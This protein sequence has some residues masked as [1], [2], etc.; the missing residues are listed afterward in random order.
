MDFF[1]DCYIPSLK[2]EIKINKLCF[3]DF[4]QCNLYIDNNDYVNLNETFDRICQ[5]STKEYNNLNNLDKFSILLQLYVFYIN[6]ILKLS[7]KDNNDNKITYE[8]LLKDVLKKIKKYDIDDFYIPKKIFYLKASEILNESNKNI[9]EIKNHIKK[10][11]IR[12][13]ETPEIIKGIPK[14]YMNCFDNSL[15]YFL[16]IL[17]SENYKN[18]IKKIKILKKDYNFLLDEI[19]NMSPKEIAM[20]LGTK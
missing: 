20:F 4:Y 19:Y 1:I 16:K 11:K 14:I 15:F 8:I 7:A 17:Y 13:F 3:G 18:F 12:L 9:E 10:N 2:K 5:K 6:S